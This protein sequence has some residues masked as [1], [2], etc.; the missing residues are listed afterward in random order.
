MEYEDG[1]FLKTVAIERSKER[2]FLVELQRK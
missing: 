2:S 1:F